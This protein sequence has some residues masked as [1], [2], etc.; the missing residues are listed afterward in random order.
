MAAGFQDPVIPL[1]E[2]DGKTGATE[3]RHSAP[4]ELKVGD[5]EGF[6]V[7]VIIPIVPHCPAFGVKV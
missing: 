1:V 7:I 2:T 5:T 4:I 3:P 6:T